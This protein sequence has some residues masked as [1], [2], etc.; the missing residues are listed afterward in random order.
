MKKRKITD[1]QEPNAGNDFHIVWTIRKCLELLN[2]SDSGLK[3]VAVEN[4]DPD[5]SD[6]VDTDGDILLGVDLTEYYGGYDF[7]G[8]SFVLVSQLKYST[9]HPELE[10]TAAKLCSG[11]SGTDGSIIHRLS[12]IYS[13]LSK[14]F[15]VDETQKKLRLKLVTNRPVSS[16]LMDL[17]LFVSSIDRD[18][19][20]VDFTTVLSKDQHYELTRFRNASGL[21]GNELL[22]FVSLIDFSDSNADSRFEQA[23]TARA[24]LTNLGIIDAKAQYSQLYSM[25]K[26]KTMPEAKGNNVLTKED[27]LWNFGFPDVDAMFPVPATF[28]LPAKTVRREQLS[29][30]GDQIVKAGQ[31]VI[32]LKGGAGI[33]KTTLVQSI[34]KVL[35]ENSVTIFFDCYGSGRY[36]DVADKRHKHEKAFLYLSNQLALQAGTTFLINRSQNDDYYLAEFSRRIKYA[37]DYIGQTSP[38]A[39]I[40]LIIDAADN[41]VTA[42]EKFIEK[43]FIHDLLM[44]QLP[45]NIR[46]VLSS[47]TFR[48]SKLKLPEDTVEIEIW[49]FSKNE[50]KEYVNAYFGAL[51]ESEVEEFRELTKGIPRVMSYALAGSGNSLAEKLQPLLPGGKDLED[52]FHMLIKQADQRS[53]DTRSSRIMFTYLITL[54]RPVP[55]GALVA[56]TKLTEVFIQDYVVDVWSGLVYENGFFNFRDE[57]FE[58]FL[59]S[60]YCPS[61]EVYVKISEHFLEQAEIEEYASVHLGYFLQKARQTESLI[62]VVLNKK[63]L[64]LP[65]DQVRNK[66][67]FIVRARLAMENA[68]VIGDLLNFLKLQAVTAEVS[69]TD[70]VLKGVMISHPELSIL[71]SDTQT[72]KKIYNNTDNPEWFGRVH[73][74]S[75]ALL[76]RKPES[77]E[78]AK[79][80]LKNAED[81]I[82]F[83]NNLPDDKLRRFDISEKDLA[84]GGEAYLQLSGPEACIKW[85]SRWSPRIFVYQSLNYFFELILSEYSQE[86]INEWLTHVDPVPSVKLLIN[87]HF[88]E[89][90]FAAPYDASQFKNQ[91]AIPK[92]LK[93][94]LSIDARYPLMSLAEQMAHAGTFAKDDIEEVL[95]IC[96]PKVPNNMASFYDG[97]YNDD[98]GRPLLDLFFR[99]SILISILNEK[100]ITIE[101]LLPNRFHLDTSKMEYKEKEGLSEDKKRFTTFY[102]YLIRLYRS[103]QELICGKKQEH[104]I[105]NDISGLLDDYSRDYEVGYRYSNDGKYFPKFLCDRIADIAFYCKDPGKI[106]R[107]LQTTFQTEQRNNTDILVLLAERLSISRRFDDIVLQILAFLDQEIKRI[108]VAGRT[109]IETYT[110]ATIIASRISASTGKEY[111]DKLVASSATVDLEAFDQMKCIDN[112][113]EGVHLQNPSLAFQFA[114]FAE[115]CSERLRDWDGFPWDQATDAIA[116]L[117]TLSAFAVACRWDHRSTRPIT[118]HFSALLKISIK[119]GTI[120]HRIAAAFMH[121]NIIYW[122]NFNE[123][124]GIII[125]KFDSV[126]DGTGKA[127]FVQSSIEDL[128]LFCNQSHQYCVLTDFYEIIKNG[129]FLSKKMVDDFGDYCNRLGQVIN[130]IDETK[131][132]KSYSPVYQQEVVSISE[133]QAKA[134]N[135][136]RASDLEGLLSSKGIKRGDHRNFD[137]DNILA[138]ILP[139][140]KRDQYALHMSALTDISPNVLGYYSFRHALNER[141]TMWG[142]SIE[143]KIWMRDNFEK[144]I[145]SRFSSYINYYDTYAFY[146]LEEL[147]QTFQFSKEELGQIVVKILPDFINELS[148]ETLWHLF[149]MTAAASTK[150]QKEKLIAWMLPRWTEAIKPDFADGP[151]YSLLVVPNDFDALLHDF[152]RYH[153]A[154]P[155]KRIRWRMAR[156]LIR[157][158]E[159]GNH[160]ILPELLLRQEEQH[161]GICQHKGFIFYTLSAK[162]WLWVVMDKLAFQG[163][164]LPEEFAKPCFQALTSQSVPH[165]QILLFIKKTCEQ[166]NLRDP[167]IYTKAQKKIINDTLTSS[168]PFQKK[169]QK[170]KD[171]FEGS[172][173][174]R[175]RFDFDYLETIDD[176]FAP[177]GRLFNLTGYDVAELAD[178]Y[179][180]EVWG[181]AGDVRKDNFLRSDDYELRRMSSDHFPIVEDLQKYFEYHGMLCA[182]GEL[183][184]S[185][186]L[187]GKDESYFSWEEWIEDYDLLKPPFWYAERVE[188]LPMQPIFWKEKKNY[189]NSWRWNINQDTLDEIVGFK[190][191]ERVGYIIVQ[192]G[193]TIHYYKD[194]EQQN[195]ASALVSPKYALSLLRSIQTG[196][197][198][199]HYVPLEKEKD[200][201]DFETDIS[202]D[203]T[204]ANTFV[205]NGWFRH[206]TREKRGIDESD[207]AAASGDKGFYLP[208]KD[209]MK[210]GQLMIT[211]DW[212]YTFMH[213]DQTTPLTILQTWSNNDKYAKHNYLTSEGQRIFINTSQLLAFLM[214]KEQVLLLKSEIY[215]QP[216]RSYSDDDYKTG[217][218]YYTLYYLIYPD[219]TVNTITRSFKIG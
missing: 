120:D 202:S 215:R 190:D 217:S 106:I 129:R 199:D 37:S 41:A 87:R 77:M 95:E 80:H 40:A 154:H 119:N 181:Y 186:A 73:L 185:H 84:F 153:L 11:K 10:W 56:C 101:D 138:T 207:A 32:C 174:E 107:S 192:G 182:A 147:A 67:V 116:K 29:E 103:R 53:G 150:E 108:V 79:N 31:R 88:F 55:L 213:D 21:E 197:N 191:P 25:I 166:F 124:A 76:S 26:D 66:E 200:D 161:C 177:L 159:L 188:H 104:E 175:F 15:G 61:Q 28:I 20:D 211:A 51:D 59:S 54:P 157:L 189:D 156:S 45:P 1:A 162:V 206:I 169:K 149:E 194:F 7:V 132:E 121:L 155:D 180:T 86:K 204:I 170:W 105:E 98:G 19:G 216:D 128:K 163:L 72:S 91:L 62:D 23:K 2:F 9:R 52:I 196:H 133:E 4:L 110:K 184:N 47:R 63:F 34:P 164:L 18:N 198:H 158:V 6:L 22:R 58:T 148:A 97:M 195:V 212:R 165:A 42:S 152:I 70:A 210:W 115:Y 205:L 33:G 130:T 203:E 17:V 49:P 134:I 96:T 12:S 214:D 173:R 64:K 83:R 142:T 75:A 50:A 135:V 114:R 38:G 68:G 112:M 122:H 209:L 218:S 141:I 179:I 145:R 85:F 60:E 16:K 117:D 102:K 167:R 193:A 46:L 176:W 99:G 208:G 93:N 92:R 151:D 24:S 178:K 118:K 100:E 125:E 30:I 69:K 139:L 82:R 140:V 144:I 127:K 35:P 65:A 201:E 5:D 113:L 13:G 89:K 94:K 39:I 219:G 131:S 111:F 57:D 136:T 168:K 71:F 81:W 44:M 109:E 90:G 78:N 137:A 36:L 146:S 160:S 3:A 171:R 48:V 43:C 172:N 123:L 8:S 143:V 126:C 187:V 74:R 183:I 14:Q 27:I